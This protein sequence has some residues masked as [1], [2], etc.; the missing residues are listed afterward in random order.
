MIVTLWNSAPLRKDIAAIKAWPARYKW[1]C[2]L[3]PQVDCLSLSDKVCEAGFCPNPVFG[4]IRYN[5]LGCKTSEVS[6]FYATVLTVSGL[7][8]PQQVLNAR[9]RFQFPTLRSLH[10]LQFGWPIITTMVRRVALWD[11]LPK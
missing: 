4:G 6:P 5:H 9:T 8:I 7:C 11:D 2:L 3:T 1:Y 10:L